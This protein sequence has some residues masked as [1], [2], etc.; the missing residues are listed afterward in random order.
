MPFLVGDRM[1]GHANADLHLLESFFVAHDNSWNDLRRRTMKSVLDRLHVLEVFGHKLHELLMLQIPRRADNQIAGCE[2]LP[3]ETED[4]IALEGF[5]RFLG[6]KDR[7][8]QRVILPEILG[9]D[10][11]D[12]VVRAV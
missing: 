8:A 2:T 4:G 9:K 10:L 12:E 7:L 11:V 6:S 1:G 3:V 5:H